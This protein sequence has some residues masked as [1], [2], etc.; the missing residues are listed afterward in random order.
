M[1]VQKMLGYMRKA[2]TDYGM[3]RDGDKVL[4]GVS[5]GKD[6]MVLLTGLARLRDFIG[7]DYQLLA[8][9]LDPGFDGVEQD[10]A[11]IE[12]YCRGLGVEY[13]VRRT[14]I[15]HIVFDLRQEEN[16]CSL[17]ARMRRGALHDLAKANGC[18]KVALG[19]H[20]DDAVET[21]MMN[22]FKEGRVGCFS[23]VTYL[24]RKDLTV[25]RPMVYAPERD[26]ARAA[27]S[28]G[29]PIVKSRCPVDRTTN[30]QHTK[31]FLRELERQDHGLKKRILGAIQRGHVSDW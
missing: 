24:S 14:E 7:I 19:H 18:N 3:L 28:G 16:P 11:A 30:R 26:V 9:T 15:G 25:I 27:R 20:A 31:D 12:E 10:Y 1:S 23:P 21:F 4:V 13:Q 6:S 17:C 22:L 5:G 8:A 29:I 2:I